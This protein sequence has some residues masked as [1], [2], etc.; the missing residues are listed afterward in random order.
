MS[1]Y[2]SR[3]AIKYAMAGN[4]K[5]F[6]AA[7]NDILMDRVRDAVELKRIEVAANFMSAEDQ[8]TEEEFGD[9]DETEEV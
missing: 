6:Q 4:I 3:E 1:E 5:D 8:S 7:V 9:N 2:T